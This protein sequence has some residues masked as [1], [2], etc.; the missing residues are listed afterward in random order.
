MD[1]DKLA[2]DLRLLKATLPASSDPPKM[3]ERIRTYQ[4][5]GAYVLRH[6]RLDAMI[7]A[8]EIAHAARI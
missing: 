2:Q 8:L 5:V 7:E 4:N 6:G 3:N 1:F